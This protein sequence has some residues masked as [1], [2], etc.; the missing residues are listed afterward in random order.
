MA[1]P[2]EVTEVVITYGPKSDAIQ[3][4]MLLG[5]CWCCIVHTLLLELTEI[6]DN[7]AN[8]EIYRKPQ[9]FLC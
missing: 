9:D 8:V 3:I 1:D 2:Q 6:V 4:L 5:F 7:E